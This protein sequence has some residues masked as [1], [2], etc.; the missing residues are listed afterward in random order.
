[1]FKLTNDNNKSVYSWIE[2]TTEAMKHYAQVAEE[3]ERESV[4]MTLLNE[5]EE[6]VQN[7][8]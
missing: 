1:L 8:V 7:T 6:S 4:K 5:V 3:D 2:N